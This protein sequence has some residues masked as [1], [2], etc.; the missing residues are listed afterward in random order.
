MQAEFHGQSIL[1]LTQAS[2]AYYI[3]TQDEVNEKFHYSIY[4]P[5]FLFWS[6]IMVLKKVQAKLITYLTRE[7]WFL[8]NYWFL[9]KF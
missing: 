3:H 5:D 2:Q 6:I 1:L 7:L 4:T 8:E 9:V